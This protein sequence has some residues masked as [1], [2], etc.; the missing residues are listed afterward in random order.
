MKVSVIITAFRE[1]NTVGRAIEAVLRDNIKHDCEIIVACPDKETK[2]V[3]DFYARNH[4]N[5]KHFQDPG[6]G[7]S[8]ALNLILKEVKCDVLILTD[9]DVFVGENS[10]A[11]LLKHFHD[12]RAGIVSGRPVSSSRKDTMLGFWSHLLLDAGAHLA[13]KES[14]ESGKLVE[15]SGYLLAMRSGILTEIPLNVAEDAIM[16]Y[17]F[18]KKGYKTIYE[19]NAPV[20]VKNPETFSDFVKQRVRTA[21][22]HENL[23][24]IAPDFPRVKS[25]WNEIRKGPARA[26]AYPKTLK[27]FFWALLLFPARLYIWA[28]V[29]YEDRI[30]KKHY[31]DGW[32]RVESTK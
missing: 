6:R 9:G 17:L 11:N 21:K 18:Q 25:F 19:E 4:K 5:I 22:A 32:D 12:T 7:K 30:L 14:F 1:P 31:G 23:K 20:Y 26:L 3:V 13:R 8:Y 27:E 10:I 16:P 15:A 2:D 28:L 24:R 29:F